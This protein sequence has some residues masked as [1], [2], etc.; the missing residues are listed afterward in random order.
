MA[1]TIN[2][3]LGWTPKSVTAVADDLVNV[4]KSLMDLQDE[5]DDSVPPEVWQGDAASAARTTHTGLRGRLND[6]A[7]QVSNVIV[8]IDETATD[9]GTA[10][11]DLEDAISDAEGEGFIVDRANA[12]IRTAPDLDA[13][14]AAQAQGKIEGLITRIEAA[15]TKAQTADS[16]LALALRDAAQGKTDGGDGSLADAVAQL[17][18]S[19]DGLSDEKLREVLAGDIALDTITAFLEAKVDVASWELEGRA[20]ADYKVLADGT[21]LMSL[22]LE[23]GLGRGID[24][25]GADLSGSA[26]AT[27]A[28]ELKFD[29]ADEARVF[30]EQLDDKAFDLGLDDVGN[31]P[32]A[33]AEN[34]AKHIMAQDVTS[35]TTGLYGKATAEV[36]HVGNAEMRADMKYDWVKKE[37]SLQGQVSA[38]ASAKGVGSAGV[39][40]SRNLTYDGDF[41]ARSVSYTGKVSA[42]VANQQ[43]GIQ[44]PTGVNSST[45]S[46]GELAV[47]MDANNAHF[48]DYRD[49]VNRGDYDRAD[50]I[51]MQH[52]KVVYRT[53]VTTDNS[54]DEFEVDVPVLGGAEAK[55]GVQTEHTT[56]I[57]VKPAGQRE[58]Y[59]VPLG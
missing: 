53:A 41:D 30:L 37:Y 31:V 17:P 49:A 23:A 12:T 25:G 19:L 39:S 43:F 34:V 59:Q 15:L 1:I 55:W 3:L 35:F 20:Q 9:I 21:V 5:I 46:M 56:G 6:L 13:D 4:R 22:S 32:A 44:V 42:S 26:G 18:P 58:G 51:A 52:G 2:T 50:E 38:N 36:E 45:G 8:T 48:D 11:S 10:K 16:N 24:L 40:L 33:V 14:E 47:T 29:S 54:T 28:L 57:Y 27:T 7:A